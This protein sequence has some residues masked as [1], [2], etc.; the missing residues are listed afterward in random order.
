MQ[1]RSV[2]RRIRQDLYFLTMPIHAWMLTG[3]GT[4]RHHRSLKESEF[5]PEGD[6]RKLQLDRLRALILHARTTSDFYRQRLSEVNVT[7]HDITDLTSLTKI[8][9]LSKSDV[10]SNLDRGLLSTSFRQQELHRINT[11][12]STGEP[13]TIYANRNQLEVR[14]AATLRAMQST[15]WDFGDSQVRLWHQTLGMTRS[16][17]LREKVD[18]WLLK[19]TFIPAFEF[20]PSSI[21]RFIRTVESKKP[22]LIDGYAESLN[23]LASYLNSGKSLDIA[24]R[25]VV[26]SAQMLPMQTRR[27]I[28]THLNTRVFDKYGSREFSGIAYECVEGAGHHVV[29]ECYIVEVLVDGRPAKPGEIGEV[30]ITDLFNYATPMIRYR[31]GDLAVAVDPTSP[32]RCGRAHSRIG[33]IQGRTQA[34]VHCAN[35]TWMPGTFF[36]HFFKDYEA[37]VRFFQ[38]EQFSPGA[39][40]LNLVKGDAF[41]DEGVR[42]MLHS[43]SAY[44]G[45]TTIDVQIVESIPLVRTG[46]RSPVV[47]HVPL[48]FQMLQSTRRDKDSK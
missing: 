28:E 8:P 21:D 3:R 13:F 9:L 37:V 30:V 35:G 41:S 11:S 24:P 26:S 10:R 31:I 38:I 27:S 32:C 23:F 16:Q 43:L 5:W 48:D 46:K 22:V 12:G 36:A 1:V 34:I 15:G 2:S 29:D 7:E 18:A 45:S 47:S 17:V 25:A 6:L 14:F 44:V 20:S 4:R 42:E 40:V 19:R 33:E 39:F